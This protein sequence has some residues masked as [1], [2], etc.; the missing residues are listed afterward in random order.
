MEIKRLYCTLLHKIWLML[1][2]AI[3]GGSF[4]YYFNVFRAVP[5]YQTDSTLYFIN[6]DKNFQ[7][8]QPL[9]DGD[10]DLSH[11][12]AQDGTEI[13]HSRLVISEAIRRLQIKGITET[14]LKSAVTVRSQKDSSILTISVVWTDPKTAA[15][16][17]NTISNVL[18]DKINQL[19]NGNNVNVL[20]QAQVPSY[21]MRNSSTQK[22][23]IGILTGLMLGF[24]IAYLI[25]LFDTTIYSLEEIENVT[26]L[27]V[28]GIIPERSLK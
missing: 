26:R 12:L 4:A 17:C 9:N 7:T 25:A 13:I 11:Q 5:I 20:D 8:G 10:L 22:I 23:I 27:K 24:G 15:L 19:T 16:L 14:T 21:P 6:R 3:L 2:L 18:V 28:I 1:L